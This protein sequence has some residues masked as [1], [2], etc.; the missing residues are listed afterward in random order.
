MSKARRV[1]KKKIPII[2]IILLI[3]LVGGIIAGILNFNPYIRQEIASFINGKVESY[4]INDF[5]K[6]AYTENGNRYIPIYY[7]NHKEQITREDIISKFA[8]RGVEIESIS[9]TTIGTGTVINTKSTAFGQV[10]RSSYTIVI[11][12]DVNRRRKS[13]CT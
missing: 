13:K 7:N 10:Y 5:V 2:R 3:A 11:Y 6:G 9:S 1:I 12:G 8:T 4:D